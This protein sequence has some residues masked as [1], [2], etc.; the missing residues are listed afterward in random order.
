MPR[1]QSTLDG[2]LCSPTGGGH[3]FCLPGPCGQRGAGPDCH[4]SPTS[5]KSSQSADGQTFAAA[6]LNAAYVTGPRASSNCACAIP[7]TFAMPTPHCLPYHGAVRTGLKQL[8]DATRSE[9]SC[10]CSAISLHLVLSAFWRCRSGL[11][12]PDAGITMAGSRTPL[13]SSCR[14]CRRPVFILDSL[15]GRLGVRLLQSGAMQAMEVF[16]LHCVM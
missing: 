6:P 9:G 3:V 14:F 10:I 13:S 5:E 16:S 7:A 2:H 1:F 12:L 11:Q 15:R 4:P 8:T